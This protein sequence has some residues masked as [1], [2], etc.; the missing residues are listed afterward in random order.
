MRGPYNSGEITAWFVRSLGLSAKP[1]I[2]YVC[3][4]NDGEADLPVELRDSFEIVKVRDSLEAMSQLT[5]ETF[6]GMYWAESL[7][8]LGRWPAIGG[9][10]RIGDVTM[11]ALVPVNYRL[12][13]DY[14]HCAQA[15]PPVGSAADFEIHED[16][17]KCAFGSAHPGGANF[18]FADGATRFLSETL[19]LGSLRA[20]CTRNGGEVVDRW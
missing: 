13:F 8:Y 15:S 5:R 20:L 7:R 16:R 10:K 9:R 6:A 18:A 12:P 3:A 1:K 17:R 14:E 2:L 19:P 4:D 11:S